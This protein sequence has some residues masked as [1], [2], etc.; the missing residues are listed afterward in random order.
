MTLTVL[1]GAEETILLL[2]LNFLE[3]LGGGGD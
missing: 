3:N 2:S 1:W